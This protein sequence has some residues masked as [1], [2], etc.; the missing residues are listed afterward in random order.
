MT[1][2]TRGPFAVDTPVVRIGQR[3]VLV[4]I[5]RCGNRKRAFRRSIAAAKSSGRRQIANHLIADRG[6][7]IIGYEVAI[8]L[9]TEEDLHAHETLDTRG[10][11]PIRDGAGLDPSL[12]C[13]LLRW[14]RESCGV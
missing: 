5:E 9:A 14:G 8:D 10:P 13:R 4:A 11:H 1:L 6:F 3:T 2:T 12:A 7:A